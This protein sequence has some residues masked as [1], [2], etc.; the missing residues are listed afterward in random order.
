MA[1]AAVAEYHESPEEGVIPLNDRVF[2][3]V[4]LMRKQKRQFHSFPTAC[5]AQLK[6]IDG[7][8]RCVDCGELD[9]QWAAVRYGGL[10]CLQCSGVHRS[11]GVQVSTVRSISMDEWSLE[12]VLSM[13]E[14]GN[15]QLLG[16]FERHA[17]SESSVA[18]GASTHLTRHNVTRLRYKTKAALFYRKQMEKHVQSILEAGPYQGR[19]EARR[20]KSTTV[21]R[22]QPE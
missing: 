20:R 4:E 9:P 3:E 16:F 2:K 14:G 1:P 6:A 18:D 21:S 13:L 7:N 10:L 15:A 8:H 5:A 17:L 11:L 19:E 12:E 22:P